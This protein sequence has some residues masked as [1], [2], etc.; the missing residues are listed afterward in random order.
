MGNCVQDSGP[1]SLNILL[2]TSYS[3]VGDDGE[4]TVAFQMAYD[5]DLPRSNWFGLIADFGHTSGTNS[6]I[7]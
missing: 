6:E 1:E 2:A 5:L 4:S 7:V 3:G